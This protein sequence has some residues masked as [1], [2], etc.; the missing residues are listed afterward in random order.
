MRRALA[1]L[2]AGGFVSGTTMRLAEPLL[3]NVARDLGVGVAEAGALITGYAVAYGLFQLVHGPLGD[4]FGKLRTAALSMVLAG[5]ACTACAS[6]DGLGALTAWRFAT[7]MTAGAVIPLSFAYLGD[8]VAY[9]ARQPALGRFIAGVLAGQTCGPLVGGALA[10]QIGWRATFVVPGAG[11]ALIGL[12]LLPLALRDAPAPRGPGRGPVADYLGIARSRD[13]RL[14]CSVVAIEGALFYGAFASLGAYLR[15]DFALGYT[16]IGL[17]LAAFGIGGIGYSLGVR[18]LLNRLG[19]VRM[20]RTGGALMLG[21][22]AV[23]A[24]TPSRVL[25][26]PC[27]LV[28]G[29]GFYMLHNTLQTHATEMAPEARG[30]AISAFAMCLFL[31]QAIGAWSVGFTIEGAGYAPPLLGAGAGLFALAWWFSSRAPGAR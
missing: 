12:A 31:G 4:R 13:A 9:A 28:L 27:V 2:A 26:A 18:M 17:V 24:L 21:G 23:L 6:A 7:G 16:A 20:V 1:L 29:L 30:A 14:V 11:F 10:D 19:I 5:A 3:P 25:A 8:N 22:F 15:E